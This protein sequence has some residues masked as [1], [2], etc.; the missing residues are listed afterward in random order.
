M[1]KVKVA[2]LCSTLCIPI[3]CSLPSSSVHGILQARILEW[4][5]VPFSRGSS[6]PRDWTQVSRIADRLE[7]AAISLSRESSWLWSNP[8]LLCLLHWQ[9][10]YLPLALPGK[11]CISDI[12]RYLSFSD[13]TSLSTIISRSIHVA[14]SGISSFFLWLSNIPLCICTTSFSPVSL[15]M[16]IYIASLFWLL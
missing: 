15:L 4:V 6:Q 8:C 3:D 7:W 11:P 9:A 12:I 16:D 13:L 2:Q 14:A 10:G 1:W 5:A